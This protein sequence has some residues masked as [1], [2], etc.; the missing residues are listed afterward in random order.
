MLVIQGLLLAI[1]LSINL[2]TIV[3]AETS[4]CVRIGRQPGGGCSGPPPF[5]S[6]CPP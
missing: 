4:K 3:M 6:Q 1:S 2:A 5:A